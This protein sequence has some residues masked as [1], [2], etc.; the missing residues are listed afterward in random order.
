MS[1]PTPFQ[2][3]NITGE[4]WSNQ[5]TLF[6][7]M[8]G[9]FIGTGLRS[10][11]WYQGEANMNEGFHLTR[12]NYGCLFREMIRDWRLAWGNSSIPFN[13][14]QLHSCDGGN[15]GQCYDD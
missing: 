5:G 2:G 9:P 7:S 8:I 6:S 14:V 15:T 10:F 4:Y 13:L 11:L 3:N 12:A 1:L